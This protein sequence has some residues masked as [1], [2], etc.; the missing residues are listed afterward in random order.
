MH[1]YAHAHTHIHTLCC[2]VERVPALRSVSQ[3]DGRLR[4]GCARPVSVYY[5]SGVARRMPSGTNVASYA[6]KLHWRA[7]RDWDWLTVNS[8]S[9][10][11]AYS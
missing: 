1:I 4:R 9:R 7:V 6:V 3:P 8:P 5:F 2:A 11:M 10:S